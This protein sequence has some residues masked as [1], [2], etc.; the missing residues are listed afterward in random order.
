MHF[1]PPNS[2]SVLQP[3][4]Q[5]IIQALKLNYRSRLMSRRLSELRAAIEAGETYSPRTLNI[6][7]VITLAAAAWSAVSADTINGCWGKAGIAPPA[8]IRRATDVPGRPPGWVDLEQQVGDFLQLSAANSGDAGAPGEAAPSVGDATAAFLD[9]DRDTQSRERPTQAE[10]VAELHAYAA[11]RAGGG[12]EADDDGGGADDDDESPDDDD[13]AATGVTPHVAAGWARSLQHYL[14]KR[15]DAP[16]EQ[17]DAL[18][19]IRA[20]LEKLASVKHQA[21]LTRFFT[22]KVAAP[23]LKPTQPF[24]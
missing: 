11:R 16:R 5:G 21:L 2:T 7:E 14:E 19:A 6:R 3:C 4:D 17:L 8:Y 9:I 22:P 15:G 10:I 12:G 23:S 1:L 13:D 24:V 20:G 18:Q